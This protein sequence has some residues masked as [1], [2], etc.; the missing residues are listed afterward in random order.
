MAD[1]RIAD[2]PEIALE[3]ITGNEKVPTGGY[4]NSAVTITNIGEFARTAL[5]L[6]T[7]NYVSNAVGQKENNLVFT[8][9]NLVPNATYAEIPQTNNSV[10]NSIHQDLLDR[11]EWIKNNVAVITDHQALTNRSAFNTHPSSSISHNGTS[12]VSIEIEELKNDVLT[13]NTTTIPELENDIIGKQDVIVNDVNLSETSVFDNVPS[14]NNSALNSSLQSLVNRDKF[15]DDKIKTGLPPVF[16]QAF[17]DTIGGYP[18]DARLMLDDGDIVQSTITNN[19]NNPNLD[20]TG[21]EYENSTSRILDGSGKTQQEINNGLESIADLATIP[22]PQTGTRV[23]VKSYHAGLKL[24]GGT[25]VYDATKSNINDYGIIINGWV[26]ILENN[27]LTPYMFGA[28]GDGVTDDAPAIQKAISYHKELPSIIE[29]SPNLVHIVNSTLL[30]PTQ[31]TLLGNGC[32]LKPSVT[33]YTVDCFHTAYYNNGVLTDLI[34]LPE[35]TSFLKNTKIDGFYLRDFKVGVY[36]KNF[37]LGCEVSNV[38]AFLCRQGF[39]GQAAYFSTW[40]KLH[41]NRCGEEFS[42]L[43]LTS[44]TAAFHFRSLN[45]MVNF[46]DVAASSCP[47]GYRFQSC[48]AT[49][50][51]SLDAE[52]CETGLYFSDTMENIEVSGNYIEG[53]QVAIDATNSIWHGGS[54]HNNFLNRTQV[55]SDVVGSIAF[56]FTGAIATPTISDNRI[57]GYETHVKANSIINAR[58]NIKYDPLVFSYS[59]GFVS[60]PENTPLGAITNKNSYY[61]NGVGSQERIVNVYNNNGALVKAKD[62]MGGVVPFTYFGRVGVPANNVIPF[63]TYALYG[64]QNP[65]TFAFTVQVQTAIEYSEYGSGMFNLFVVAG[66]N[67]FYIRGMFAGQSLLNVQKLTIQGVDLAIT[68]TISSVNGC[69][70]IRIAGVINSDQSTTHSLQGFVKMI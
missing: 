2:A 16:D 25:F 67:R 55:G 33:R 29:F 37:V 12:N 21:W 56:D 27:I 34:P 42:R 58:Q 11:M 13:I 18:L 61:S 36:M 28:K 31:T 40:R 48:Q 30:I 32:T 62:Y 1:L 69:F 57:T 60:A 26:R 70:V 53:C 45:G 49:R 7:E 52:S 24:G 6:A 39:H 15:I 65:T 51:T 47:L 63:C 19:V 41:A 46:E 9:T 66:T 38:E 35:H 23:Y 14:T 10:L 59:D 3:N 54:I 43:P 44:R 17:A 64:T 50:I 68:T 5:S 4:G 22:T 8:G 20:M